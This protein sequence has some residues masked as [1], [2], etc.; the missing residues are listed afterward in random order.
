MPG[1]ALLFEMAKRSKGIKT[2]AELLSV[3]Q[4]A[5]ELGVTVQRVHQLVAE[6]G[7]EPVYDG[8]PLLFSRASM[9]KMRKRRGP[10]RPRK[11]E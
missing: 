2:S 1:A 11:D 7:I 4:M 5:D 6:L 3:R 8:K 9:A 10:G